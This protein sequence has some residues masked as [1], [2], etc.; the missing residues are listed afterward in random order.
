MEDDD[1]DQLPPG[2]VERHINNNV[3]FGLWPENE[4]AADLFFRCSTQW[5]Y[6]FTTRTGL[7]Y[8]ALLSVM[9][10]LNLKRKRWPALFDDIRLIERG[11]LEPKP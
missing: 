7:D 9:Q 8:T 2:F 5:R 6:G 1:I 4:Q 3:V 10:M 11:A